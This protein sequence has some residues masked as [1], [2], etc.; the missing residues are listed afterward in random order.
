MNVGYGHKVGYMLGVAEILSPGFTGCVVLSRGGE[1][2]QGMYSFSL[3]AWF[4]HFDDAWISDARE[5]LF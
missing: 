3:F 5:V 2:E 1:C 4:M